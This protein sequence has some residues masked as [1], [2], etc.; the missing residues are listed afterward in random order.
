MG[1][2]FLD[3]K[4][5][6]IPHHHGLLRDRREPDR[7]RG[8]R[9]RRTTPTASSGRC[10]WPPI[11]SLVVPLQVQ[12]AAVMEAAEALET[13][14]RRRPGSTSWST[15]ATSGPGVKFKDAD[16]IGIPLRV[17]IGERGLKEGTIEV[18][19][20]TDA[21]AHHV[22]AAT[23]GEAILAEVAAVAAPP[24]R[25]VRR[26]PDGPG[27][28]EAVMSRL[29]PLPR[30]PYV[31]LGLLTLVSFGGPFADLARRPRRDAAA[32]GPPTAPSSGSS[33]A[34][35]SPAAAALFVACVTVGWWYPWPGRGR[36]RAGIER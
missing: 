8:R 6:E 3:E 26:A 20:R 18:K 28:G 9:G 2:T 25:R 16:L 15:T 17:V 34:W 29:S 31:L 1:A 13:A 23:A 36:G 12:N 7:R 24:R 11:T 27:R 30:L 10:R 32:T 19:W 14:A 21:A 4:G 33:S 5:N 35:S 22:P